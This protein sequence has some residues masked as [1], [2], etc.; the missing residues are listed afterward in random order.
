MSQMFCFQCEQ[1]AGGKACT[2][3]RGVCGKM[4]D[5]SNLLDDMTGALIALAKVSKGKERK[6]STDFIML[7]GLFTAITN[8]NFNNETIDAIIRRINTEQEAY[9][10]VEQPYT[11]SDLW[12]DHEDIRSLKS[13]I[14][15]G[16]RGMGA[17]AYHAWVLGFKDEK[18]N[19][20]FFE[21]MQAIGSNTSQDELLPLVLKTGEVNLDCMQML[22][23]ANTLTYGDPVPVEVP[24]TIEKGPFIVVS[25]HDLLDLYKL[26]EQTEGKGINIYTH[27]EMLPAHGYPK[28]KAF[29]HLKGNFGTAWQNQQKEFIDIA[30][31]VLFT[32]N[33]LMPPKDNY[34][35]RIFTTEV[36][37]FPGLV[38]IGEEKDFTPVIEKALELGG[39]EE[40]RR[41]T[42]I[43][44]GTVVTTGFGRKTVLSIAPH[45]V[46]AVKQ[47]KINHF[48]L[49]GGCDG[50]KPGRNYYTEFVEKAPH[51]TVILTVAC[52]KY[53]FNDLQL[54]TIEGIPRLVDM[55]QCN[56]SYGAIQVAVALAK[57]FDC[58]VNDLP[59]TLILSWYEQKAVCVLLSLLHLGIKNIHLGP[60]L[61]AFVSPGVL[62]FLVDT[63]DVTPISTVEEDMKKLLA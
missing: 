5:T 35:D 45:I 52:G 24:L 23:R 3:S 62:K 38:H 34:K 59:L 16:L 46:D 32:T 30:G 25:G 51:D 6:P 22:D 43:N 40:D 14:L 58:Q 33:C 27:G 48:F 41:L 54:G 47:G 18:I 17:Y 7:E 53:R 49:V 60:T 20:F 28:L 10:S 21:A 42:G 50:A 9:G 56:D 8:V 13:L 15:L 61:P 36:V 29:K 1:T 55:G 11:M 63:F 31:P 39:F 12:Q 44:G 19:D 2:G 26:L 4:A 37:S 57:A